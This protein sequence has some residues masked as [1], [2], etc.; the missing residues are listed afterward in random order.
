MTISEQFR[1]CPQCHLGLGTT[2]AKGQAGGP[3]NLT[4]INMA[5][6]CAARR[7]GPDAWIS[8]EVEVEGEVCYVRGGSA[9][10]AIKSLGL[11][12]IVIQ[13]LASHGIRAAI[14]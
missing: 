10:E 13:I 7:M 2:T 3:Q 1:E 6:G 9:S 4:A 5:L 8:P 14:R 12:R 11:E